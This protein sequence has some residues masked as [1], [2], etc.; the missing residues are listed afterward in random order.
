[1]ML[2]ARMTVD[3]KHLFVTLNPIGLKFIDM[4]LLKIYKHLEKYFNDHI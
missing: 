3:L 2:D 1:M 4:F